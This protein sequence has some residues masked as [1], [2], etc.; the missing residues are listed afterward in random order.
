MPG[1]K[2]TEQQLREWYARFSQEV[3]EKASIDVNRI[4]D[5]GRIKNYA[6][7]EW[8]SLDNPEDCEI[9]KIS[10]PTYAFMPHEGTECQTK[11]PEHVPIEEHMKWLKEN[12]R[13]GAELGLEDIR[14]LYNMSRAGTL[15]IN[16]PGKGAKFI[17]Q[18]YTDKD[19]NITTSKPVEEYSTHELQRQHDI[20]WV[21]IPKFVPIPDPAQYM[22][23][24]Q[25]KP[26]TQPKNMN[27]GWL[28][29]LGWKLGFKNTDYGKLMDYTAAYRRYEKQLDDCK[30]I[31]EEEL[32]QNYQAAVERRE[33]FVSQM[34]QLRTTN[35]VILHG[36]N[37]GYQNY[38]MSL[39]NDE[40]NNGV[41]NSVEYLVVMGQEDQ[42][43]KAWHEETPLGQLGT[44]LQK[45]QANRDNIAKRTLKAAKSLMGFNQ[46]VLTQWLE[47]GVYKRSEINDR[48]KDDPRMPEPPFVCE[49]GKKISLDEL[50]DKVRALTLDQVRQREAWQAD[51][52]V[53]AGLAGFCAL[54]A[55]ENFG[56]LAAS[57]FTVGHPNSTEKLSYI[58]PAR[59]KGLEAVAAWGDGDPLKI[60]QLFT[61]GLRAL[62]Q[63]VKKLGSLQ[64]QHALGC[65]FMIDHLMKTMEI[66]TDIKD[67]LDLSEAE[68]KDIELNRAV[69]KA[70]YQGKEARVSLMEYAVHKNNM[71][72]EELKQ[73]ALDILYEHY[74][75]KMS[76]DGT[77]PDFV[78]KPELVEKVK[79]NLISQY[80]LDKLATMERRDVGVLAESMVGFVKGL[81]SPQKA[82]VVDAQKTSP[83]LTGP[84]ANNEELK[85]P[86][87]KLPVQS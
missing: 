59:L 85:V 80:D 68:Q 61:M 35:L 87:V 41:D 2:L 76:L 81:Y 71:T 78:S 60:G 15:M 51:M 86:E 45:V 74:L 10:E 13:T 50:R 28:S 40:I 23:P 43:M 36:V 69:F 56:D 72:Q 1:T 24:E 37:G 55:N 31:D 42:M 30:K 20:S 7:E 58:G 66:K 70:I 34:Q 33:Q 19:G 26:P 16:A 77:V 75:T 17:Q 12:L 29:W 54:A 79:I 53:L 46:S 62:N 82:P 18:V 49:P 39:T 21:G 67:Y 3:L 64:D 27:P 44:A 83:Q 32:T 9:A 4:E 84:E 73:A 22:R 48:S 57:F 14:N 65:M 5:V 25:P 38:A 11:R 47:K 52:D 8:G 63:E 6:I